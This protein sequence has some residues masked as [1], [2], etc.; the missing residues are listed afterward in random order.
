MDVTMKESTGET[1]TL[2]A[3][4]TPSW[5]AA[6]PNG[7]LVHCLCERCSWKHGDGRMWPKSEAGV[8]RQ[9][10]SAVIMQMRA[11]VDQPNQIPP[12]SKADTS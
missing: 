8:I 7:S 10:I 5:R 2:L 12:G 1:T 6:L 11:R 9:S 4:G 3:R